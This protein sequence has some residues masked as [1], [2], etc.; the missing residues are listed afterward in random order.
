MDNVLEGTPMEEKAKE[1]GFGL[2]IVRGAIEPHIAA[3]H[4]KNLT[5]ERDRLWQERRRSVELKGKVAYHYDNIIALLGKCTCGYDFEANSRNTTFREEQVP[6][7][8]MLS[9]VVNKMAPTNLK[10]HQA[11]CNFYRRHLNQR[12][13]WHT[14]FNDLISTN[15]ANVLDISL[16]APGIYCYQPRRNPQLYGTGMASPV[17]NIQQSISQKASKKRDAV[18]ASGMRGC[19]PVF[20]G[21]MK[22]AVGTFQLHNEHKTMR[23]SELPKNSEDVDKIMKKYP[24]TCEKSRRLLSNIKMWQPSEESRINYT[25]RRTEY[26]R[27]TETTRCPE[28]PTTHT[29][30]MYNPAPPKRAL[31]GGVA[32]EPCHTIDATPKEWFGATLWSEMAAQPRDDSHLLGPALPSGGHADARSQCPMPPHIEAEV[33][34]KTVPQSASTV[35]DATE[36]LAMIDQV[37]DG[38]PAVLEAHPEHE[39]EILQGLQRFTSRA[40]QAKMIGEINIEAAEILKELQQYYQPLAQP[41]DRTHYTWQRGSHGGSVRM[42]VKVNQVIEIFDNFDYKAFVQN[43]G[44]ATHLSKL[45]DTSAYFLKEGRALKTDLREYQPKTGMVFI[46]QLEIRLDYERTLERFQL[47]A[48]PRLKDKTMSKEKAE[49]MRLEQ[50]TKD[51]KLWIKFIELEKMRQQQTDPDSPLWPARPSLWQPRNVYEMPIVVWIKKDDSA[52]KKT[53]PDRTS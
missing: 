33:S 28:V 2:Y 49:S 14:D 25:A 37:H 10:F 13:E 18:I 9:T 26:H 27:V 20:E 45:T 4:K 36:F 43:K 46:K 41:K 8:Q 29:E 3:A 17:Y 48:T 34:D 24:A 39:E 7:V 30:T 42:L 16:G 53:T 47:H 35:K 38:L 5:E 31:P 51:T 40:M 19:V 11:I 21:D 23:F 15:Q 32:P 1:L 22:V 44:I 52:G 50:C 12:V 6:A